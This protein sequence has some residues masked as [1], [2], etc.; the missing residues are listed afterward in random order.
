[1]VN[2]STVEFL[3]HDMNDVFINPQEYLVITKSPR[4]DSRDT[5]SVIEMKNGSQ[6]EVLGIPSEVAQKIREACHE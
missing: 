1:M 2:V 3:D 4:H 5:Y 6:I